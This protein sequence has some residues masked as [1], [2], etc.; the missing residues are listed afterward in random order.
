M[1]NPV[2]SETDAFHIAVRL[3]CA[4]GGSLALG[5][6][7]DPWSVW[8]CSQA[9]SSARWSGRS[10]PRTRTVAARSG[11]GS[12]GAARARRRH[13]RARGREPHPARRRAARRAAP[14]R[15]QWRRAPHRRADPL[16]AHPLHRLGRRHELD[17][18]RDRLATALAWAGARASPSPARS[19]TPTRRSARSRTSSASYG[20]D[21]VII[22]TYPAASRTGWRPASSSACATELDIPISHVVVP[23]GC[24]AAAAAP[25]R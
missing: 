13:R 6:L 20:A 11:G 2:R 23:S 9:R 18:A 1:R 17:E 14:P 10:R 12:A 16:L 5:A 4:H 7:L 25:Q 22:S 19:A 8:R 3:R 21:E 24:L 15:D